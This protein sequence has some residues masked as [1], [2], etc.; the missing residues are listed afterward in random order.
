MMS[1]ASSDM[2]E[3]D[4]D[5]AM[6]ARDEPYFGVL[7]Q[8]KFLRRNLT[9]EVM[10]AFWA[11]GVEEMQYL[12]KVLRLHFGDF[13]PATALDFGCGVGRLTRAMASMAG[14]VVGLD[15][16]PGML[17]EARRHAPANVRYVAELGEET[18]DWISSVIVFQHIPPS[19][20]FVLL[21]DLMARLNPGGAV[22]IQFTVFK[23]ASFLP[24][25]AAGLELAAWDGEALKLLRQTL[26]APGTMMMYDYDLTRIMSLLIGRGVEEV[27]LEHTNHGGCHGVRLFGRRRAA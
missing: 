6:I 14:Q 19:R 15:V 18:F 5:W 2:R 17:A 26:P 1:D 13:Q 12:A 3:T 24:T 22:S 10:E 8:E 21:D 23:D 7:T 27:F 11:S 4:Q 9:P 25:V 16:A 20:G